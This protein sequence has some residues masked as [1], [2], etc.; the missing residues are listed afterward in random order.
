MS[1]MIVSSCVSVDEKNKT[2][3]LYFHGT[4]DGEA[5]ERVIA[6]WDSTRQ[7]EEEEENKPI[8][9]NDYIFH[10]E[11]DKVVDNVLHGRIQRIQNLLDILVEI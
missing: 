11:V 1:V 4:F 10:L 2:V 5:I 9:G 6:S 7:L 8:K 3:E